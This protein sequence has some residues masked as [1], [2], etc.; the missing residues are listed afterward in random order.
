MIP[1]Y[2]ADMEALKRSDVEIYCEFLTGNWVVNKNH[3]ELQVVPRSMFAADG[4]MLHCHTKK[5]LDGYPG[6]SP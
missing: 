1:V 4:D 5:Q 2:L 3:H 6:E